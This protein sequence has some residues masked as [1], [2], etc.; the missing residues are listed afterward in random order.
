M[1]EKAYFF[2]DLEAYIL[3]TYLSFFPVNFEVHLFPLSQKEN[4]D[5]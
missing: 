4:N 2:F 5:K 1:L 3:T